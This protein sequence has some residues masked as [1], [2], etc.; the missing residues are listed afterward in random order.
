MLFH[1]PSEARLAIAN[2][3]EQSPRLLQ[4]NP[5][6]PTFIDA[7]GTSL[8]TSPFYGVCKAIYSALPFYDEQDPQV[9]ANTPLFLYREFPQKSRDLTPA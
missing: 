9:V 3:G 8:A 4:A 5:T 6:F 7:L 1:F 2:A